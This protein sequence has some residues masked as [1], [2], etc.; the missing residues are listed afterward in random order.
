MRLRWEYKLHDALLVDNETG[1]INLTPAFQLVCSDL[2]NW[3]IDDG[4][5]RS[6]VHAQ[7]LLR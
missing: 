2:E 3:D 4:P 6:L 1:Q 7:S 5:L